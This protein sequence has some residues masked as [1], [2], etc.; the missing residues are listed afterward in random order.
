MSPGPS[1]LRALAQNCLLALG[2]V[3]LVVALA[4][5]ALRMLRPGVRRGKQDRVPSQYM[6]KDPVLGWRK[7]PNATALYQRAEYTVEV[8]VNS[9]GLRD[10]ERT[11]EAKPGA[12]RML[13][14]GDS[15][16]EGYT[17]SLESTVT[18][19]LERRL[20]GTG[21]C[22]VEVL[23]GGTAGWSTDQEYLYYRD[24]AADFGARVVLLFLYYNDILENLRSTYWGRAKPVLELRD[25]RLEIA[26]QPTAKPGAAERR[27]AA[28]A[29]AASKVA[30]DDADSQGRSA[31]FEFL[32]ERLLRG[33]P[34]L[35]QRLA[36]FGFWAALEP[37]PPPDEMRVFLKNPEPR[38]QAAWQHTVR[39]LDAL[40]GDVA[41]KGA[42]LVVVYVPAAFEVDDR[43][44][45]LTR[46]AYGMTEPAW[47]RSAVAERLVN[48]GKKRGLAV[49]DLS[50]ALR[51]EQR[52]GATYFTLDAHWAARG[53]E[54]AARAIAAFLGEKGYLAC[55][56]P[57]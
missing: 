1:G 16:V 47:R 42:R 27:A 9:L 7:R 6:S 25:G 31:L 51:A 50:S 33:R 22:P 21:D 20:A 45:D 28:Q 15:F 38:L 3:A 2:S 57:G 13:A 10:P 55:P 8:R 5:V 14:L 4:E 24:E 52:R 12:L 49:I 54:A 23:N 29:A 53:H 48:A 41:A 32:R 30:A 46:L 18:Q 34:S 37:E 26:P 35:Y 56:S 36:A 44:W 17:V 43:A 39:I 40:A 11:R 19:Q